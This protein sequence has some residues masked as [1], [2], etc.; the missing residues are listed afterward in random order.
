MLELLED[1]LVDEI[2]GWRQSV[3]RGPERNGGPEGRHLALIANHHGKL[4]R[5]IEDLEQT[6]GIGRGHVLVVGFKQRAAGDILGGT[7]R[8]MG[9]YDQL[10]F[11]IQGQCPSRRKH[12]QPLDNGRV[13]LACR[14][15][16]GDPAHQTAVI[17]GADLQTLAASVRHLRGPLGHQQA[18]GRI[19]R[20]HPP[21]SRLTDEVLEIFFRLEAEQ[22]QTKTV[23]TRRLAM[24]ATA[25]AAILG[26]NGNN[27]IG[28]MQRGGLP[29]MNHANR[30]AGRDPIPCLGRD[31]RRPI[32]H[33]N[34]AT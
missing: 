4:T 33:R 7:I 13:G 8:V 30:Q 19:G 21:P 9:R 25:V 32:G 10:L 23:L 29:R 5:L 14:H 26:E 31:H 28:E 16:L 24:A 11:S 27:L 3:H 6:V 2:L 34:D 1:Q 17:V 18:T 22:G 15:A 12:L 20:K